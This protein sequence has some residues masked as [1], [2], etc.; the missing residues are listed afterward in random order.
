ML[1]ISA[2]LLIC[3]VAM[4]QING[5]AGITGKW[6]TVAEAEG[7]HTLLEFKADGTYFEGLALESI[8][9]YKI[10]GKRL[11]SDSEKA[12]PEVNEFKVTADTLILQTVKGELQYTRQS[13]I[14][15]GQPF[16]LG[17]WEMK[18]AFQGGEAFAH[19]LEFRKDGTS[20]SSMVFKPAEGRYKISGDVLTLEAKGESRAEKIRFKKGM[21]I[22]LPNDAGGEATKFRRIR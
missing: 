12:G 11:Y 14:I 16:I 15:S 13:K 8:G 21:L 18:G 5:A 10:R 1:L 6:K 3:I 2:H 20:R 9:P 17:K 7:Y 22:L 4:L 19:T